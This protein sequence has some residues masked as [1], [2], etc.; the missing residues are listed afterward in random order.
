[1]R[2]LA[3]SALSKLQNRIYSAVEWKAKKKTSREE[4]KKVK[5]MLKNLKRLERRYFLQKALENVDNLNRSG[6]KN[7][8]GIIQKLGF[9]SCD[10]HYSKVDALDVFNVLYTISIK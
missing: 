3:S 7:K 5:K 8:L 9:Q 2:R 6:C 10:G 4:L 1:M